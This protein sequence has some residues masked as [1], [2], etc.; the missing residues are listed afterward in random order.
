MRNLLSTKDQRQLR[1]METLIQN[2]NWMKL[3]ELADMAAQNG[4]DVEWH[5][6]GANEW[7]SIN[8]DSNT[9]SVLKVLSQYATK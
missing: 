1:L 8:G 2:R 3:H 9:T 5:G 4:Y 6:S 7:V